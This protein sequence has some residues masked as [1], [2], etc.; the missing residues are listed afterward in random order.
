[1]RLITSAVVPIRNLNE[2]GSGGPG[3]DWERRERMRKRL[4]GMRAGAA[5]RNEGGGAAGQMKVRAAGLERRAVMR[6]GAAGRD[7]SGS[8]GP[9][10]AVSGG[11]GGGW[12]R[13]GLDERGSGEAG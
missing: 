8:G 2:A 13:Q 1:M 10:E 7:E 4:A 5:G 6:V 11:T 3:W 9:S 12:K